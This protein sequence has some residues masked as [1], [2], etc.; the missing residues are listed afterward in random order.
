MKL[1][2]TNFFTKL[3]GLIRFYVVKFFYFRKVTTS[4]L[5]LIGTRN[6]FYI[7]KKGKVKLGNR[8]ITGNNVTVQCY[9]KLTVGANFC[10]NG[11]SR[12]VAMDNVTIGNNV[13]VAQ[14]VSILDHDHDYV[15]NVDALQ[16]KGYKKEAI[17]IGNNVWIG[18]KVSI[19]KG[20]T[21]GDNV[22]IGANS[23][24]T[25]DIPSNV[26]AAGVPA[27]VLKNSI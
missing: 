27:R 4:K 9:G 7:A 19:T 14:F 26:I 22:I 25:K 21:I 24:V 3:F 1:Y 17:I 10:L 23:V 6:K 15:I 16:L 13:T 12:I 8:F 18:D 5:G 20:V 11:Y 2:H